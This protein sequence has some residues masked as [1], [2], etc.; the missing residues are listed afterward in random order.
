V[1]YKVTRAVLE[2]S[3]AAPTDRHV[4]LTIADYA[5]NRTRE[6]RPGPSTLTRVTGLNETTV[7]RAVKRL[8]ELGELA[9]T[10]DDQGRRIY[11]VLPGAAPET[12]PG[13]A[14]PVPGAAPPVPGAAPVLAPVAPLTTSERSLEG[15]ETAGCPGAEV[16]VAGRVDVVWDALML[17]CGV[18]SITKAAR[19]AYNRAAKDLREVGA[20][21]TTI[22]AR[23]FVFRERWP[24]VSLTPTALARRWGECDPTMQHR[25][26]T[27]RAEVDHEEQRRAAIDAA[28][29]RAEQDPQPRR[30]R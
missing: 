6:A 4:L 3:R 30:R 17:V 19:G 26:T 29:D 21:P 25:P 18:T 24:D 10:K 20:T 22:G 5:D 28:F 8:V 15:L 2:Q 11:T 23:A 27:T 1:G 13:A 16:V 12:E 9:W 14:P 7:R